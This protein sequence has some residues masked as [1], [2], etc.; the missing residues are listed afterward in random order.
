[1]AYPLSLGPAIGDVVIIVCILLFCRGIHHLACRF[2]VTNGCQSNKQA[3][4]G[5]ILA[6]WRKALHN[7]S[8]WFLAVARISCRGVG[9][10]S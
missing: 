6:E 4:V 9:G 2:Y 10:R 5:A 3:V 8:I 1:M 7:K